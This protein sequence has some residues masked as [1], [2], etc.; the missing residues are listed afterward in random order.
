MSAGHLSGRRFSA[1]RD[2]AARDRR[3]VIKLYP[4]VAGAGIPLFSTGFEPTRFVLADS[5][6]LQSGTVILSYA[7]T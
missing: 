3:L 1:G 7:K 2:A 5:Q 6:A 4:V